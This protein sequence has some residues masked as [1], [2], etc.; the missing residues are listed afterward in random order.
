M[1]RL[2]PEV[3]GKGLPNSGQTDGRKGQGK[4]QL[5]IQDEW[6]IQFYP[7]HVGENFQLS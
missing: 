5:M 6:G 3:G 1:S 4:P 7:V 2:Y